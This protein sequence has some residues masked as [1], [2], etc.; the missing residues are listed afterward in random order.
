MNKTIK[1][2]NIHTMVTYFSVI[3]DV[4]QFVCSRRCQIPDI[5]LVYRLSTETYMCPINPIFS[6]DVLYFLAY[7]L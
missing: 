6:C 1:F 4:I 5:A 2:V 3:V 7:V